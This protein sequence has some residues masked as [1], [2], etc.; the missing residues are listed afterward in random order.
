MMRPV[1][2]IRGRRAGWRA[3]LRA[4]LLAT[5]LLMSG[6]LGPAHADWVCA[7]DLNGDG[8]FTSFG[9]TASCAGASVCPLGDQP[10]VDGQCSQDQVCRQNSEAGYVCSLNQSR[11]PTGSACIAECR[12]AESYQE[13]VSSGYY[14]TDTYLAEWRC[15]RHGLAGPN[16]TSNLLVVSHGTTGSPSRPTANQCRDLVGTRFSWQQLSGGAPWEALGVAYWYPFVGDP[17]EGLFA[18]QPVYATRQVWVDTSHYET[19]TRSTTGECRALREFIC[20]ASG[21]SYADQASCDSE[22]RTTAAC[23]LEQLCPLGEAPCID[24][25]ATPAEVDTLVSQTLADDGQ[26]DPQGL[27]LD[28]IYI[29]DGR[30][31]ECRPGG[32]DTGFSSCCKEDAVYQDNAAGFQS[33]KTTVG[34][35]KGVYEFASTVYSAYAAEVAIQATVGAAGGAPILAA[36]AAAEGYVTGLVAVPTPAT[37]A[38]A[39][40]VYV[41]TEL[42]TNKCTQVDYETSALKGSKYCHAV[43]TYCQ[44][45]WKFFGCVQKADAYC[46]Y[47]SKLARII[48]EQGRPQLPARASW[49]DP[50]SPDCRGF[51]PDE[52]G[53][54]DFSRIDLSE[55]VEDIARNTRSLIAPD[56]ESKVQDFYRQI[57]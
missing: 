2:L 43:G 31:M 7:K 56:L 5:G 40:A 55:Y 13:W 11:Y 37:I 20:D 24:L 51:T 4:G 23:S 19:R 30:G 27:C 39:V 49:G 53:A 57:P 36:Q 29:F 22:C 50:K 12:S 28:Q 42:L 34:V 44:K 1:C 32:I 18:A 3:G 16:G 21:R 52:F 38:I 35:I 41:V 26:R 15:A 8:D 54:I 10:C 45:K 47:N 48:N 33:L 14:R 6:W 25:A 46:C 9:E 17:I